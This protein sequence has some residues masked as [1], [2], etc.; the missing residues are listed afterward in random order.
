MYKSVVGGYVSQSVIDAMLAALGTRPAGS[1]FAAP[2][3]H[4]YDQAHAADPVNDTPASFHEAAFTGYTPPALTLAG[5]VNDPGK[6]RL[7]RGTVSYVMT[8]TAGG[9]PQIFGAFITDTTNAILYWQVQFDAPV[10]FQLP[11]DFLDLDS[12]FEL[13]FK[14]G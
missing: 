3:V 10:N 1:L 4:L 12:G 11:G 9:T 8:S 6:G 5:P 13:Q 2:N 7:W 14:Q